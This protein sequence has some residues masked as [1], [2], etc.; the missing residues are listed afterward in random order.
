[1]RVA[2]G[3]ALAWPER[4]DLPVD[5]LDFA[6]LARLDFEAPDEVRFPPLRLAREAM[7][8]GGMAACHMNAAHEI[9]LDGF[10]SG[11]I[12]F[13]DMA[14]LVEDT[15]AS[16]DCGPD[17]DTI[18]AVFDADAAARRAARVWIEKRAA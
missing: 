18:D 12:G 10:I 3:Y 6:D 4:P 17:P 7:E 16:L 15:V 5:R 8:A 2:I 1:M 9:A 11:Q 14:R 13:L